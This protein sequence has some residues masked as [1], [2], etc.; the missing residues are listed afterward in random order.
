MNQ[1]AIPTNKPG[2]VYIPALGK[3]F[4]QI[5]LREDDIYDTVLVTAASQS[6]TTYTFWR[7]IANKELQDTNLPS[8]RRI[9]SGDEVAVFRIGVHPRECVGNTLPVFA[10]YRKIIGT[11]HLEVKFNRRP[12]TAG[13]VVKYPSGFGMGGYSDETGATAVAIGV[14]SVAAAPT[15]FVPQQLKD[16]DD[17]NATM[18]FFT[19]DWIIGYTAPVTAGTLRVTLFL[20]GVMKNPL[21]K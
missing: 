4:Q 5:E 9:Q 8:T 19:A 10:D 1:I 15:L 2:E 13:P 21:G 20:H 6:N 16:D 12:I 17:L 3:T 11:A 7:D 18:K 14:P